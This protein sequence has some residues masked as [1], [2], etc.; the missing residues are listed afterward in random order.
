MVTDHLKTKVLRDP[1]HFI[2][3]GFGVGL[4]PIF[5][6][7]LGS[8][9]GVFFAWLAIHLSFEIQ[10]IIAL[11]LFLS[12][13][14]ICGE[15]QERLAVDDHSGIVWDEITGIYIILI[16]IPVSIFH[17][18]ICFSLF[19]L[20]DIWKPWPIRSVEKLLGGGFGIMLDD[21]LAGFYT[22]AVIYVSNW[23]IIKDFIK[24][25]L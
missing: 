22:F 10:L 18:I 11:L 19:R 17:W 21:L 2:A 15:S 13:V 16:L 25:Y 20:F 3:F 23:P 6:G 5:P 1:I 4:S 12:G 8:I 14:Y 7:T 9:I 24:F